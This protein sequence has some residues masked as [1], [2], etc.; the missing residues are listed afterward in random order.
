MPVGP[1]VAGGGGV[2]T[3]I[4]ALPVLPSDVA[5]ISAVPVATPV[6][7]PLELTVPAG[8]LL[9]AHV[10]VRPVSML[11]FASLVIAVS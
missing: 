3:A 10:I 11:P 4:I 5:V 7:R 9:L 6:T 2:P 8:L 1:H